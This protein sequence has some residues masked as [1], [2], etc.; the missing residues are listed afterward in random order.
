MM[1][2]R[3]SKGGAAAQARA[4]AITS[5]KRL[6]SRYGR[7][8]SPFFGGA[9]PLVRGRRPRRPAAVA[10][11]LD[12]SQEKRDEGVLAQRAPRP[13]G[14]PHQLGSI[15][16]GRTYLTGGFGAGA[17]GGATGAGAG[18]G[19]FAAPISSSSISKTSVAPPGIDGGCPM[20]P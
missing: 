19:A 14:P 10:K 2:H 20:L 8:L 12:L 5:D 11:A 18:A 13:G 1:R 9:D 15:P 6:I 17:G 3:S 4:A 16:S 7:T